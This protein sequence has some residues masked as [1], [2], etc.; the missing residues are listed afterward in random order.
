MFWALGTGIPAASAQVLRAGFNSAS[1][2]SAPASS[3]RNG[4]VGGIA[5]FTGTSDQGGWQLEVLVQQQGAHSVLQRADSVRITYLETSYLAHMDV[6]QF[7]RADR[8]SVFLFA[9]PTLFTNLHASYSDQSGK[10]NAN[11]R[12][13]RLDAGLVAGGGVERGRL[14]LEGRYAWGFRNVFLNTGD[15]FKN[16]VFSVLVGLRR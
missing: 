11:D 10:G 4:F 13:H 7:G 3:H 5:F 8:D 16:R 6:L 12:I 14:V 2:S 9:G 1:F 15:A